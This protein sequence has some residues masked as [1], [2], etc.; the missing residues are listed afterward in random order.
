VGHLGLESF[1][2][3]G[4]MEVRMMVAAL[5]AETT[6]IQA[7]N[8]RRERELRENPPRKADNIVRVSDP[9]L[10]RNLQLAPAK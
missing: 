5:L 4:M 8:D 7:E 3:S 2:K 10:L 9:N 1:T 6:R